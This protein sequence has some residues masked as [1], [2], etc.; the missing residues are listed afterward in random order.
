M[1]NKQVLLAGAAPDTSNLGV[2]ALCYSTAASLLN[3]GAPIDLTI[4]N[5]G[6]KFL[7]NAYKLRDG[8]TCHVMG[9]KHT[10][11]FY[12]PSSYLNIEAMLSLPFFETKQ[13]QLFSDATAILDLSAGDSFTD[14]YGQQRFESIVSP[15]ELAI[16]FQ[17]ALILLPQTYGPFS[18]SSN[19]KRAT[20][21][22]KYS[23]LAYARDMYSL[24]CMQQLLGSSFDPQRHRLAVDMAFLLPTSSKEEIRRRNLLPEQTGD[25]EIYGMNISGLIYNNPA[26]SASQYDININYRSLVRDIAEKILEESDGDLWLIPHV[27]APSGS[28]ESDSDA[29]LALKET[30]NPKWHNRVSVIQGEYDQ[31]EIK[32]VISQCAWFMGTR[33]HS[34]IAALSNGIPTMALAYSGKFQGVFESVNQGEHVADLRKFSESEVLNQV[35]EAWRNRDSTGRKLS[36]RIGRVIDEAQA[37]L[38]DVVA[39]IVGEDNPHSQASIKLR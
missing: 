37:Q 18:K 4:L 28:Y 21:Y 7:P 25:K 20:E 6:D 5:H 2:D 26:T 9:A 11:R 17:K 14:L 15:K 1:K 12:K 31:C 33:M 32:G 36:D 22:L 27:L 13:S 29:C 10:R 38:N 3:K 24:E 34:T 8:T 35:L 16:K 23:S 30:L 19:A 39:H